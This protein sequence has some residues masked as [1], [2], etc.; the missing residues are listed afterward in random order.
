M[1]FIFFIKLFFFVTNINKF[2]EHEECFKQRQVTNGVQLVRLELGRRL[3]YNPKK[4]NKFL[5]LAGNYYKYR[6]AAKSHLKK[7]DRGPQSRGR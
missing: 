4:K 6:N 2:I 5:I 3:D 1:K 7:E